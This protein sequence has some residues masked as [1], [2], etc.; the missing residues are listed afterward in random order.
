MTTLDD[1]TLIELLKILETQPTNYFIS[2]DERVEEELLEELLL[3]SDD[4]GLLIYRRKVWCLQQ[5]SMAFILEYG[6]DEH[7][8]QLISNHQWM[9]EETLKQRRRQVV[10]S[11]FNFDLYTDDELGAISNS[12]KFSVKDWRRISSS[13]FA[14][15][16]KHNARLVNSI[17][18]V[19]GAG[20]VYK[21][22]KPALA[23]GL[24][25]APMCVITNDDIM[26]MVQSGYKVTQRFLDVQNN[27]GFLHMTLAELDAIRI[28]L[29]M[30]TI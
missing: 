29:E 25:V 17:P 22:Y 10:K 18:T 15:I 4:T 2:R 7:D 30:S 8:W 1:L 6:K 3:Y 27:N 28:I 21:D 11:S 26:D 20:A 13:R 9:D 14:H 12:V 16:C 23:L 5:L 24:P 19:L